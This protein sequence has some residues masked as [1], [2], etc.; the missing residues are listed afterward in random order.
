[1]LFAGDTLFRQSVGRTDLPGGDPYALIKSIK[2]RLFE[3]PPESYVVPGHGE[4]TTL[5][6]EQRENPFL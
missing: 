3:L 1:L 2:Q 6:A 4:S 5:H